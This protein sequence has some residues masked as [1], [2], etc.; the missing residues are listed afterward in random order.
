MKHTAPGFH[1]ERVRV[2]SPATQR[3]RRLAETRPRIEHDSSEDEARALLRRRLTAAAVPAGAA[4]AALLVLPA[5]LYF[6]PS[7]EDLGPPRLAWILATGALPAAGLGLLLGYSKWG[8][9][10]AEQ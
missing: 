8:E 9:R 2:V 3:A 5:L 7:L 1:P 10:A 6:Y 4:L